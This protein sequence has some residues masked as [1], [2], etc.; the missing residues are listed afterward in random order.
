MEYYILPEGCWMPCPEIQAEHEA[1]IAF[2]N[3]ARA[4][5]GDI[6]TDSESF[7]TLL[8]GLRRMLTA[9]FA[10]EERIMA[11]HDFPELADHSLH[12]DFCSAR[13]D[14]VGDMLLKGQ[15][16]PNRFLLD[17]L[18]DMIVDDVI[19]ADGPF[20]SFLEA[21]EASIRTGA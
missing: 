16:K 12:H 7:L 6:G 21:S 2:L 11:S 8:D 13:L 17:E 9:H 20:K 3:H 18:Y 14:H 5:L 19:R 1:L 10:H 4:T 15:L